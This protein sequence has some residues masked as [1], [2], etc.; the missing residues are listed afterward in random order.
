MPQVSEGPWPEV[1]GFL[2]KLVFNFDNNELL[3]EAGEREGR[4]EGKRGGIKF[5]EI[6]LADAHMVLTFQ[7]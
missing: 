1:E 7:L 6:W 2:A 3:K 4:G 5:R